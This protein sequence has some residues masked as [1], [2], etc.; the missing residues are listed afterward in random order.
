[1]KT[2]L[3]I[4]TFLVTFTFAFGQQQNNKYD[5]T[6]IKSPYVDTLLFNLSKCYE[7]GID[8]ELH[9]GDAFEFSIQKG[10]HYYN[11]ACENYKKLQLISN[12]S[13]PKA[14][15]QTIDA[16]LKFYADLFNDILAEGI[17][18]QEL[19]QTNANITGWPNSVSQEEE[20]L[21][22]NIFRVVME[23]D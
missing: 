18:N 5:D 11:Q 16:A 22:D 17:F 20:D 3:L 13:I 6:W 7:C 2:P 4:F 8:M 10:K 21:N 12:Y 1:M 9:T 23:K 15:R 14:K 19:K